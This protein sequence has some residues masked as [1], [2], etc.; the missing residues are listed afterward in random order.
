MEAEIYTVSD[1]TKKIKEILEGSIP[2]IWVEGE[3]RSLKTTRNI[4]NLQMNFDKKGFT[5]YW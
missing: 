3:I 4:V 5:V 1:I 2:K